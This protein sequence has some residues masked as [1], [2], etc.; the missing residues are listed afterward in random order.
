MDNPDE[1]LQALLRDKV[2][3]LV[4]G[5]AWV[6]RSDSVARVERFDLSFRPIGDIL[7][8]V[9]FHASRDGRTFQGFH[10]FDPL[11]KP[12]IGGLI[13]SLGDVSN[14]RKGWRQSRW[15]VGMDADGVAELAAIIANERQHY[16]ARFGASPEFVANVFTDEELEWELPELAELAEAAAYLLFLNG[17][18][19]AARARLDRLDDLLADD[20]TSIGSRTRIRRMIGLMQLDPAAA[21]EQLDR[22]RMENLE[23]Y[24]LEA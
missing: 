4:I 6:N 14:P 2:G 23:A 24:G 3:P 5:A 1:R 19:E 13:V 15:P 11:P 18:A 21:R 10:T 17:S 8:L 12:G 20:E 9:S 22:W 16:L 7:H